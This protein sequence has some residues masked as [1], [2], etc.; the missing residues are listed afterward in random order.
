VR[1]AVENYIPDRCAPVQAIREADQVHT[2]AA[3]AAAR[4]LEFR[5]GNLLSSP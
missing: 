1:E 5:K 2:P 4:I 3:R